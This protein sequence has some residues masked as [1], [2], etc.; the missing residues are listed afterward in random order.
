MLF[1]SI[2]IFPINLN[3]NHWTLKAMDMIHKEYYFYDSYITRPNQV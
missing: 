2:I 3:K 1:E